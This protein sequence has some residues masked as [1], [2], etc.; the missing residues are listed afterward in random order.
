M[1]SQNGSANERYI[2][3]S[4]ISNR[5]EQCSKICCRVQMVLQPVFDF[6]LREVSNFAEKLCTA[7]RRGNKSQPEFTI[8]KLIEV[9]CI[10]RLCH[11][12]YSFASLIGPR[13]IF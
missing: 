7:L 13:M 11:A 3:L 12:L 10:S 2:R 4:L 5:L 9:R 8:V 1:G 6:P